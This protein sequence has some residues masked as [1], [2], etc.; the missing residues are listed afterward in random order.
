M[1]VYSLS[2]IYA[3]YEPIKPRNF[4]INISV[5]LSTVIVFPSFA[6]AVT[7]LF[8]TTIFSYDIIVVVEILFVAVVTIAKCL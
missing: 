2:P 7:Y 5:L 4:E 3:K 6:F 8:A 1:I